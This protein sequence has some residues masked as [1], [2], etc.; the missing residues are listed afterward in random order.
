[1]VYNYVSVYEFLCVRTVCV[2]TLEGN[3]VYMYNSCVHVLILC[4]R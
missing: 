3:L 2:Y 1:M 4:K